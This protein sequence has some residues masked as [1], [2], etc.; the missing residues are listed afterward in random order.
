M[1]GMCHPSVPHS[2]AR[3]GNSHF[4]HSSLPRGGNCILPVSILESE[5]REHL[6]LASTVFDLHWR[7]GESCSGCAILASHTKHRDQGAFTKGHSTLLRGRNRIL[8]GS[9]PKS[10][11]MQHLDLASK[12]F[13]LLWRFV[14]SCSGCAIL[15]SHTKHRDQQTV[16]KATLHF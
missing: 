11:P 1:F 12:I 14:E 3:P 2:S 5:P 9:I 6:D 13:D 4:A 10:E 8:S 16:T 15:A 7:F